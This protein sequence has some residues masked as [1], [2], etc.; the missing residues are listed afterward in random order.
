MNTTTPQWWCDTPHSCAVR[1]A[2]ALPV[3]ELLRP[4]RYVGTIACVRFCG[5]HRLLVLRE[6]SRDGRELT[7]W[8][9]SVAIEAQESIRWRE[10]LSSRKIVA[11]TVRFRG[12]FTGY[13]HAERL[14]AEVHYPDR[15]WIDANSDD[16]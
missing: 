6:A 2:P 12:R 14:T 9:S 4:A 13:Q 10:L 1:L 16:V 11:A 3:L 5:M 15:I 7:V 8:V